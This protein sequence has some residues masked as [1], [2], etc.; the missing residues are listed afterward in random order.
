VIWKTISKNQLITNQNL[1]VMKN[2]KQALTFMLITLFAF[3]GISQK[4]D[5]RYYTEPAMYAANEEWLTFACE[6]PDGMIDLGSKNQ[7]EMYFYS[8]YSLGNLLFRSGM[9]VHI[10]SNP[11]FEKHAKEDKGM[12][13]SKGMMLERQKAFMLHKV[14]QFKAK[15]GANNLDNIF[16]GYGPVKGAFP[17]YL[18]YSSGVPTFMKDPD[19]TDFSTLR[20][21]NK[22]FDQTMNPGAWGQTLTKQI[23]WARDFFKENRKSGGVTYIGT[24]AMDGGHGFRG[25]MLIAMAL[26]KSYALKSTLAYNA[27][28]EQ[29]G[30]VDPMTYDPMKGVIYYPHEYKVSEWMPPMEGMMMPPI[31]QA[32]KV[33]DPTSD[34]FDVASL[35]WGESEFYHITDPTVKDGLDAVF[36]DPM[37]MV[38]G[39]PEEKIQQEL[40]AGKTIFPQKDPHMLSK[41]LTAVNFKNLKALHFDE[42][43]MTFVDTWHPKKGKGNHISTYYAGMTIVALTNVSRRMHDV[44]MIKNGA[45]KMLTAQ[46]TFLLMQQNE[47]GSIADGFKVGS[48]VKA[49]KN[50]SLLAQAFAIR[51]WLAA[52]QVTNDKKFLDA[53]NKTYSYIEKELWDEAAGV[54]KTDEKASKSKYDAMLYGAVLGALREMAISREGGNRQKVVDRLDQFFVSVKKKNGLQIAEINMTGEPIPNKEQAMKMMKKMDEMMQTNPEQAKAMKMKMMDSDKDGVPKPKFVMDTEFGA[55][56]VTAGS[57]VIPTN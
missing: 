5:M 32:F 49:D 55:A 29:L 48:K 50:H 10:V 21:D 16:A 28:T 20:W 31:P 34:L 30:G 54:Y 45:K 37:W 17:I 44:D 53:A 40:Q 2:F 4:R 14:A 8:M 51:G 13:W 41:G 33:T 12:P 52:Y 36:G 39:M 35:I 19:P 25:A 3:Q 47:D 42:A 46:A 1:S 24:G 57:V 11:L 22:S 23:L 27:N 9:G 38:N 7:S 6:V 15:S 26:T 56:P 43:N 18:E